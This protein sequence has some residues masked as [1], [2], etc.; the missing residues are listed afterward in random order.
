MEDAS[1]ASRFLLATQLGFSLVRWHFTPASDVYD[2]LRLR[3]KNPETI[4]M[5]L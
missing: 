4:L 1:C 2:G 3:Q 5:D